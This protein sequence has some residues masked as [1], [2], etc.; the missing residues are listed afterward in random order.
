MELTSA[1]LRSSHVSLEA[2]A[3]MKVARLALV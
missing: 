1:I 3:K 2:M